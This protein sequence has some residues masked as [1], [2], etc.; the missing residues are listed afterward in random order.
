M[1]NVFHRA[2]FALREVGANI[3]KVGANIENRPKV[4][5]VDPFPDGSTSSWFSLNFSLM[6]EKMI[7][8]DR[9]RSGLSKTV[10]M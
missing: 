8:I 10:L 3:E 7:P 1:I 6:T 5:Y 2:V 9:G 4:R